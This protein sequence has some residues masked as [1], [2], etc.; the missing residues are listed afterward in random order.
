MEFIIQLFLINFKFTS[1][2][3]LTSYHKNRENV[4]FYGSFMSN[5]YDSISGIPQGSNFG[6]LLFL[7][8][9]IGLCE[10]SLSK[11][12]SIATG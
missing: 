5:K 10:E 1:L 4:V 11:I 8:F 2:D 7:L 9:I 6:P 12:Q 3:V